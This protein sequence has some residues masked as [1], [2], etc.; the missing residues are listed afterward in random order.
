MVDREYQRLR[1]AAARADFLEY[2]TAGAAGVPPVVAASWE[3]SQSAGVDAGRYRVK[4][5]EDFDSDSRLARCALPVIDRLTEDMSDVPVTIALADAQARIVHRR[6]CSTAVGRLLDRIDFLPGFSFEEDNVG[7]NGIGTVF[8][9]GIP[10]SVVGSE[11]FNESLVPFACTGAPIHHPI[12]GRI[13]GVLDVS[14]LS[15]TWTPLIYALVKTAA[16]DIGRNLLLDRSQAQRAL[17]ESFI[18]ADKRPRQAVMAVGGSVIVNQRA[19]S[20]FTP[21]E[22][23]TI[24][25]HARYIMSEPG[26]DRAVDSIPLRSGRSVRI[27]ATRI[28]CGQQV[29]GIVVLLDEESNDQ[30]RIRKTPGHPHITP[31][32]KLAEGP[33]YPAGPEKPPLLIADG[34]SPAW[35]KACTD[36]ATAL[37]KQATVLVLGEPGTGKTTMLA[38]QHRRV[39]PLDRTISIDAEHI[40]KESFAGYVG[41][42]ANATLIVLRDLES[43]TREGVDAITQLFDAIAKG[44]ANCAVAATLSESSVESTLPF[45]DLLS[46]FDQTVRVPPLRFRVSDLPQIVARLLKETAPERRTRVSPAASRLISAFPWPGNIPQLRGALIS[47]LRKRPVGE[48]QAE[49]LPSSCRTISPRTLTTLEAA[50]RDAIA[51]AL[52]EYGGNRVKAATALGMSRSSL[53]R[54]LKSYAIAET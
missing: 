9:S 19:Q 25:Q 23:L 42:S 47:A 7:T 37:F 16:A 17:F 15:E 46:Y 33:A 36:A 52:S 51:N 8:E 38:E 13:E 50:E 11:H 27:R 39:R 54:K 26:D 41:A 45:R 31:I 32:T 2:G 14:L 53:Y 21:D 40:T 18:K 4:Y 43:I 12:T 34:N 28:L 22:Q 48:I 24:H 44:D 5:H 20:L 49:D 30:D 29:A 1:I 6:D 3:R 35:N 10:T